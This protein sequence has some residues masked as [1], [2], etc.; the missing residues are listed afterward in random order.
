MYR[1][2]IKSKDSKSV[3]YIK[4]LY[5]VVTPV[6]IK[7]KHV[8]DIKKIFIEPGP[9]STLTFQKHMCEKAVTLEYYGREYIMSNILASTEPDR[10]E[11]TL[12]N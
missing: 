12:I 6:I 1:T 7:G 5:C 4:G 9:M 11:A 10:V 2:Y 3:V 8:Q